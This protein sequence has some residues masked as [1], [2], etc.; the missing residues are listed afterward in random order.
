MIDSNVMGSNY[1][2]ESA[3]D[4]LAPRP[5]LCGPLNV[6]VAILGGGF[7]GL[8][9]AYYLLRTCPGIDVAVLEQEI[10]GYGASGRN[11]GWIS[12]R[13]PSS[14]TG[15]IEQAGLEVARRTQLAL[16]DTADEIARVCEIEGIDAD[17]RPTGIL[18]IARGEA[19]EA[20]LH[21]SYEGY[22]ALG[23]GDR[24]KLL[25][26]CE[27]QE[28]V[29]VCGAGNA[30]LTT[31]GGTSH[32]AKLVRGL[33]RAVERLGGV[34]Y[35][36]TAVTDIL[37]GGRLDTAYGKVTTRKAVVAAAEAYISRL[38]GYRRALLPI[39]SSIILTEPLSD[40]QWGQIGW[41]DGEGLSSQALTSNYLTRTEDGRV[42]YGSRGVPYFFNSRIDDRALNDEANYNDMHRA[43]L[44]WFPS[45]EGTAIS[46]AWGGYLGI[47]RDW[48]PTVTFDPQTRIGQL[49]GY[50]GRGVATS[51]LAA[52]LLV[53]LITGVDTGLEFPP[54][55][56]Q[57]SPAWE[58]EPLRW[59]GVR[60]VQEAFKQIDEAENN[61]R[62]PPI[63]ARLAKSLSGM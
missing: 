4:S 39:S 9:T 38:P 2:L 45:L 40:R 20:L 54:M 21:K 53:G 49:Y 5:A 10:C 63:G 62:S 8:W 14:V 19:Q 7:S 16:F 22:L 1:W 61:H 57:Q 25:S 59:L 28:R 27:L 18:T 55:F 46:H 15:L 29:K 43:L 32:P 17:Y 50:A 58:P 52:R 33:A 30:L 44:D 12:P 41:D 36:K 34:I 42:L 60:Y 51:N 48:S 26:P 11:G 3:N 56:R 24:N 37:P 6:D 35:E 13:Y 47:A 31:A 23:L